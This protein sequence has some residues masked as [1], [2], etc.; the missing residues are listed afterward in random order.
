M[1]ATFLK[2]AYILAYFGLLHVSELVFTNHC[3]PTELFLI[4]M[5]RWKK[6]PEPYLL[7]SKTNQSGLLITIRI[8]ASVTAVFCCVT[9]I[10]NYL[11]RRP[12]GAH[13]FFCHI[14]DSPLERSQFSG[15]LA[16]PI[17]RLALH[18][19]LYPSQS[20]LIGRATALASQ[21]IRNETMKRK[22][23]WKSDTVDQYIR[24]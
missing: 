13:Y 19:H 5:C 10:Q 6:G 3:M 1:K 12:I 11:C 21:G 18:A 17:H 16:K 23:R 22:G 4:L 14:N 8:P 24:L 2:A 15:V 7:Q 20:F 9:A